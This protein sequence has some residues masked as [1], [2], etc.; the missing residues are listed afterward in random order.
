MERWREDKMLGNNSVQLG[1]VIL[2]CFA[3]LYDEMFLMGNYW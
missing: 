2:L 1:P 3:L